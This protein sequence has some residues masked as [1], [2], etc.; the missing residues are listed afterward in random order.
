[1]ARAVVSAPFAGV[2]NWYATQVGA[3]ADDHQPSGLLDALLFANGPNLINESNIEMGN[4][5]SLTASVWGSRK[6]L[7]A[8]LCSVAISAPVR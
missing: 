4:S 7:G 1:M 3:H 8:T 2:G 5:Y 6:L